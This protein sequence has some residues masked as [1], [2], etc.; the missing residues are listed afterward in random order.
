MRGT[1]G[2][3]RVRLEYVNL[4][5]FCVSL[6]Y[7]QTAAGRFQDNVYSDAE[8]G[9]HVDKRV[10]AEEVDSSAQEIAHA[11]LCYTENPSSLGVRA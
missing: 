2:D 1:P 8:S 11:G 9:E 7:F 6:G 10:R 3:A 5:F 4:S